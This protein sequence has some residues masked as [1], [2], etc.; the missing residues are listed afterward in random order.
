M[1]SIEISYP[2]SYNLLFIVLVLC[3]FY[4]R[5]NSIKL[6]EPVIK[7]KSI[8]FEHGYSSIYLLRPRIPPLS[9]LLRIT[10]NYPT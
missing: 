10:F 1:N 6:G 7:F 3:A 4:E 2:H 9:N 5:T 8:H